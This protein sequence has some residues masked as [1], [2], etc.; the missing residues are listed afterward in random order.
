MLVYVRV[1]A[2]END[3]LT[4]EE[5]L[6][7]SYRIDIGRGPGRNGPGHHAGHTPKVKANNEFAVVTEMK[8]EEEEPTNPFMNVIPG[9]KIIGGGMSDGIVQ[10]G[11][12]FVCATSREDAMAMCL[13]KSPKYKRKCFDDSHWPKCWISCEEEGKN[14][15]YNLICFD[16]IQER[17]PG[18]G[19]PPG[20]PHR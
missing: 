2:E 19:P 14:C 18:G 11:P 4:Q 10:A 12:F 15:P 17:P 1:G 7:R 9:E 5:R 6:L 16:N 13:P 20:G 8:A 3:A